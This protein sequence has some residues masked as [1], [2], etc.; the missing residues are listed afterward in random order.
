MFINLTHSPETSHKPNQGF[1]LLT[2]TILNQRQ[3]NL[4]TEIMA[5]QLDYLTVRKIEGFGKI[6]H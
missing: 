3:D 1:I 6:K 5:L 4:N 2:P